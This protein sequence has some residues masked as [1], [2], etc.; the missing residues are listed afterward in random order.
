M[1]GRSGGDSWSSLPFTALRAAAALA[2]HLPGVRVRV[3]AD[4]VGREV[5]T[6][7]D[8]ADAVHPAE[9]RELVGRAIEERSLDAVRSGLAL[10]P[11]GP[12]VVEVGATAPTVVLGSGV[13]GTSGASGWSYSF[14]TDV[15]WHDPIAV[16]LDQT[17]LRTA[18]GGSSLDDVVTALREATIDSLADDVAAVVVVTVRRGVTD[19]APTFERLAGDLGAVLGAIHPLS[20]AVRG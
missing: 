16:V 20:H 10:P 19:G 8:G 13:L 4:A 15:P 11:G 3:S 17:P 9:F 18:D 7:A 5:G 2:Y 6:I 12:V 14:A 1:W